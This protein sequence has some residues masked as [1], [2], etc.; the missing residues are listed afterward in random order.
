MFKKIIF[1][2]LTAILFLNTL[3]IPVK[4]SENSPSKVIY[5]TFDD[6]ISPKM[7]DTFINILNN[8]NVKGTFFVIGNTLESNQEILK[9]LVDSG[10]GLGLHTYSHEAHLVYHSKE[11]FI[12]EMIKTQEI[13]KNLTDQHINIIRFPFGSKNHCFKLNDEWIDTIHENNMKIYDWNVDTHD[14]EYPNNEPYNIYKSSISDKDNIILLM[15]CTS[16]NKNSAIALKQT[17]KYY[18]NKNYTFKI[19]DDSTPEM[20]SFKS[21]KNKEVASATSFT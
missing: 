3:S 10:H 6:G 19:I 1:Y 14:G 15:H 17:I 12:N 21:K 9:K 2:T 8:E 4:A 16:L 13:I 5:L 7:T 18:K 20:Y 11:S